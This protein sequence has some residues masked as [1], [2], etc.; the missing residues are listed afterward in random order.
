MLP[1]ILS[2]TAEVNGVRLT[3]ELAPG[4]TVLIQRAEDLDAP[5]WRTVQAE[6]MQALRRTVSF[7]LPLGEEPASFLK[8]SDGP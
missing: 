7:L 2:A 4:Q 6:P 5:A 3:F 8:L 1:P